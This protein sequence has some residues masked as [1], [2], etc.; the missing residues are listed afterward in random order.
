MPFIRGQFLLNLPYVV[1]LFLQDSHNL[2][3][4]AQLAN[5]DNFD[6]D[7]AAG[8]LKDV[9]NKVSNVPDVSSTLSHSLLWIY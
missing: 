7:I 4:L 5:E 9:Q 1:L 3:I 2:R 8:L 6:S